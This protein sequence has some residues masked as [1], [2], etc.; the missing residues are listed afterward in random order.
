MIDKL[1]MINCSMNGAKKLYSMIFTNGTKKC[2][3]TKNILKL[4]FKLKENQVNFG[5]D[6]EY[7]LKKCCPVSD[8]L[9]NVSI[10]IFD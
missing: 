2:K 3:P 10:N 5:K 9:K 4:L 7:M 8:D 6:F 1:N